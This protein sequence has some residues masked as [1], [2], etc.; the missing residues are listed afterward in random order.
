MLAAHIY[1]TQFNYSGKH[2][3]DGIQVFSKTKSAAQMR[4]FVINYRNYRKKIGSYCTKTDF[5][6][7]IMHF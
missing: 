6:D 2:N 4:K 1:I 5:V 7:K 3:R